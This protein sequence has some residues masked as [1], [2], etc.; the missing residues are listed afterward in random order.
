MHY[1]ITLHYLHYI[2]LHYITLH[3]ITLHYITL[4]YIAYMITMIHIV[5]VWQVQALFGQSQNRPTEQQL[6]RIRPPF[7]GFLTPEPPIWFCLYH[8]WARHNHMTY[9]NARGFDATLCT[10]S[11]ERFERQ[12]AHSPPC[13]M[14][15]ITASRMFSRWGWNSWGFP[16]ANH[17]SWPCPP[18]SVSIIQVL[19]IH[20]C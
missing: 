2:T 20:D 19:A 15:F 4:Q 9:L 14:H 18:W 10:P 7:Q 16:N 6:I 17:H 13:K 1:Y 5:I 12:Q 8:I 3:Y 11:F